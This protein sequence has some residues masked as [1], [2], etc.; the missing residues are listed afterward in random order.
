[1]LNRK[2]N[3]QHQFVI[4]ITIIIIY[5]LVATGKIVCAKTELWETNQIEWM[6]GCAGE[7]IGNGMRSWAHWL[8]GWLCAGLKGTSAI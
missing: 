4:K 5:I 1:M 6:D 2:K 8:I 7:E 3:T